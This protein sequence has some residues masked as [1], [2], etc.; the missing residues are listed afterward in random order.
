MMRAA[1]R[2]PL[3]SSR[4]IRFLTENDMM[5]VTAREEDVGHQLGDWLNFRQA[6]ALHKLLEPAP[7]STLSPL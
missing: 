3:N 1:A 6:I 2:A 7:S 5:G 4:L